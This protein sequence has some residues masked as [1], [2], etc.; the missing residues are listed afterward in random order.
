MI[1]LLNF[2]TI[3]S[4]KKTDNFTVSSD[5][6]AKGLTQISL[7]AVGNHKDCAL[8][9]MQKWEQ[10][11]TQDY[12]E[13]AVYTEKIAK[14]LQ[15]KFDGNIEM[16]H[17]HD[18]FYQGKQFTHIILR[19]DSQIVS[20]FVDKTDTLPDTDDST[21]AKII[22]EKENGLQVASFQKNNRA[23]FIIS[24][25]SETENLSIARTVSDTFRA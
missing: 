23:I 5:I 21:T 18:C 1:A 14:P 15:A 3:N 6:F 11:S 19:K 12:A 4:M 8:E 10:M 20:V 16:M 9:K 25:M 13:K 22:F 17:A 2:L 7:L 24:D